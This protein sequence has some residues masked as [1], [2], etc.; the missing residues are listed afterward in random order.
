M[1]QIPTGNYVPNVTPDALPDNI[2]RIDATPDAF[3]AAIADGRQKIAAVL[4]Q[5]SDDAAQIGLQRQGIL[6][7]TNSDSAVNSYMSQARAILY[8]DPNDPSKPGFMSLHGQDAVTAAPATQKALNDLQANLGSGLNPMAKLMYDSASRRYNNMDST[9]LASKTDQET[10]QFQMQTAEATMSNA[11]QAAAINP[12]SDSIA[13]GLQKTASVTT[14][15]AKLNGWSPEVTQSYLLQKTGDLYKG[16]VRSMAATDPM[17]ANSILQSARGQMDPM[18]YADISN[19]LRPRVND[20]QGDAIANGVIS[21]PTGAPV[22]VPPNAS[23]DGVWN[24][25]KGIESGGQQFNANGSVKTS[26]I[27]GPDAPVGV[28][29]IRPSTAQGVAASAGVPFDPQRLTGDQ[30]YNEALGRTYLGQQVQKYGNVT[31]G[32]AA[33][34]AGPATIDETLKAYGD[35]RSGAVTMSDFISHLPAETQNYVTRVASENG[36]TPLQAPGSAPTYQVPDLS[37][38]LQQVQSR[39]SGMDPDVQNRAYAKVMQSYSREQALNQTARVQLDGQLKDISSAYENGDTSSIIPEQQI[40]ALLPPDKANETIQSLQVERTAGTFFKAVQWASPSDI[41]LA[42]AQLENPDTVQGSKIVAAKGG[43]AGPGVA[44]PPGV[45]PGPDDVTA[46]PGAPTVA[47]A[48]P[49]NA[50]EVA[51]RQAIATRYETLLSQRNAALTSD[52]AGYVA[53]SPAL[54]APA[55]AAGAQDASPAAMQAY[56]SAS[57]AEQQRLGVQNPRILSAG[58]ISGVVGKLSTMDPATADVGGALDQMAGQYGQ[59]WPKVFGEMVKY[60]KLDPAYQTLAA[61]DQPAQIGARADFQRALQAGSLNDLAKA[62]DAQSIKNVDAALSDDGTLADFRQTTTGQSGG[63][64]L[65]DNVTDSVKRLAYYYVGQGQSATQAVT[66][67]TNGVLNDKYDFQGT[68]RVPKGML[69]V[70]DSAIVNVMGNLKPGDVQVV[71]GARGLTDGDNQNIVYQSAKTDGQWVPN[72]DDSGLVLMR[73][74]RNGGMVP[75]KLTSGQPLTIRFAEANALAAQSGPAPSGT[76]N[77]AQAL[78]GL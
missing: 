67:A 58:Q 12:S 22:A 59:Q 9:L 64:G 39:T 10:Q 16:V 38:Q 4:N 75:V 72:A 41:A 30:G 11:A 49:P 66:S 29:Q 69:S 32:V 24:S 14:Q 68:M 51:L 77:V 74:L 50:N 19:E 6:N 43:V 56:V 76:D 3:G 63:I 7:Q 55:A 52:P 8:G 23:I 45:A 61:M 44:T 26:P 37:A 31:L 33:Y 54:A 71:A 34:N 60:G 65:M 13:L 57:L 1:A 47:G 53:S 46:T 78:G 62:A 17:Q 21:N 28:S 25:M 27:G 35:P 40:R 20:A 18:T 2:Q 36:G 15:M 73:P 48:T 70:V 5:G 42:R